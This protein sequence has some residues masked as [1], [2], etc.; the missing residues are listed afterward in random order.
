MPSTSTHTYTSTSLPKPNPARHD[1]AYQ[2]HPHDHPRIRAGALQIRTVGIEHQPAVGVGVNRPKRR[3]DIHRG[4]RIREEHAQKPPLDKVAH[5]LPEPHPRLRN[6]L[7][8]ALLQILV[9]RPHAGRDAFKLI[10]DDATWNWGTGDFAL[11]DTDTAQFQNPDHFS[12][13]M[14]GKGLIAAPASGATLTLDVPVT[15]AGGFVNRGGFADIR[16]RTSPA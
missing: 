16:R 15:G 4:A 3:T 10:F 5:R 13:E 7:D 8:F 12:L 9:H 11:V 6:R 1:E 14:Q 2:Q